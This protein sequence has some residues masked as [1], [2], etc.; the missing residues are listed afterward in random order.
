MKRCLAVGWWCLA[1]AGVA[2]GED[3]KVLEVENIVQSAKGAQGTW[4]AAA[5]EQVLSVG[6]RIRTRQRSRATLRLTDLYTMRLEQFTTVEITPGLFDESKARLGVGGGSAFI[7][8]REK[9]GEIDIKTPA[10]NGAM[11]GTQLHVEV[12]ADGTSRFQ[13]LEG[14]VELE[15]AQGKLLLGAGEAGEAAPGRAPVRT[16]V[17]E[18]TN[19]LQWALYYPAVL[20]PEEL[21]MSASGRKA[22]AKSLAAYREGDLLAAMEAYPVDAP[23]GRGDRL[24]RAAV[25]LAVGR[26]DEAGPALAGVPAGDP[27]RR[28]IERMVAAVKYQEREPWPDGNLGTAGEAI[29]ESYYRQ[30]RSD[31]AGAR[32]GARIA[33]EKAPQNG[34]AWTRLAELEFSFGRTREA[35]E[36]LA[37]GLGFT[38][39]NA[40]AHALQGF[41]LSAEN[42]I[43]DARGSF[44]EAVRLDGSLGNAWL[45]LGLTK[46]RKGDLAGG[47]ADLQT[48][49][50][51]EPTVSIFHSYLGKALSMEGRPVEARKDLDLARQ[52]DPND[53]TPW[54]YSALELQQGNRIN[55]S[56]ADLER[57]I[58]LNDNRR[59]YRSKFLLDQDRAVRG[60]NL[61]RIYQ[62]AGMQEVAVREATFAVE[63]DY[64]NPSAHLFLANSFDALR[65]P[66]RINLRYETPWFNELLLANLLGPVG[67]GPLSQFVSQQEYS[68]LLESDGLGGSIISELRSDG[69]SRTAAS[70]FGSS[71][72]FEFGIDAYYGYD[73]G[74]R[75]NSESSLQELYGQFKWQVTPDDTF[76]FLGKWQDQHSGDNFETYDNRPLEPGL[77]FNENQEPGLLLAGWNHRWAPGSNTLFLGGR[78]SAEQVLR[79]PAATQLLVERDAD[80]LRPGFIENNG[81]IDGFTDPSLNGSVGIGP[82]GE[83]LV[84]SGDLLRAIQ[85]YLGRG[86]V[87]SVSGAP[88]AFQSR[89]DFEI[90]TA[91][92]QHILQTDR[93]LL[94]A[95][96]R[97]QS[98]TFETDTLMYA[99]RPNFTGGFSTPAVKQHTSVDFQRMSL[100]AYDYWDVLPCL[101]LIGG[102]AWDHIEHPDNFRNPPANNLQRDDEEF[103][104]KIGFS[105][106]PSRRFRLR[107]VYTEGLGGVT[108]DESV[109]LEPVQL[110]GFNQAYRTVI[111][112]SIAGSVEAPEFRIWGLSADGSLSTRTWWGAAVNVIEQEVDRTRGIFTGYDTGVF[113]STPAYFADGTPEHLDYREQSLSLYLNQLLG[114]QFSVGAGLRL[115]R[116]ELETVLPELPVAVAPFARVKDEATL[117]EVMFNA[118][119]NSPC[120]FFARVEAN[121]YSQDLEDDPSRLPLRSGDSFWQFNALAGYRFNQNQCE[122]TAGVLNIGDTDY[123]LS[124]LNPRSEIVRDRTAVIRIR[125][126][127]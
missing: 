31:L 46:T 85:P 40:R 79:N 71:G 64:T 49:A 56:I 90:D 4:A 32:D 54:L 55:E 62:A 121:Y 105:Y 116:S 22:A 93:N 48:A 111:S 74:D 20:D 122:I 120:G 104:G 82:D 125:Y 76:Y 39:R 75:P 13:V 53:P 29:A 126:S 25:L 127:F 9:N 103:S 115:T 109:R 45:G 107:G 17:I 118:N 19:L 16:A 6:D 3:A 30:S 108:Y 33:T 27:G 98:G 38:P 89:R 14:Q 63:N 42:R 1:L 81:G 21:G 84:Y 52:L 72:N 15:N 35:R 77:D 10:A 65:D 61:A 24:Y 112:E 73:N 59:V 117:T 96:A 106:T 78:L 41:I 114:N 36:A 8:S 113:P 69:E 91:E 28:A 18:A 43:D 92:L 100:Y 110:A 88:F 67:G 68:K 80:G 86:D 66:K 7:F 51:V 2:P 37:A 102:A 50:T 70:L 97:W 124:A 34:Y 58:D 57:S 47:R 23:A 94:I 44:E 101:T 12:A 95:G 119:W 83:S 123:R 11:R 26:L 60:A 99:E 5:K 87:Q